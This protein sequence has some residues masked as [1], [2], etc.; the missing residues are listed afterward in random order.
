MGTQSPTCTSAS[1]HAHSLY[2]GWVRCQVKGKKTQ[3]NCSGHLNLIPL[4]LYSK[5]RS[6]TATRRKDASIDQSSVSPRFSLPSF[7]GESPGTRLKLGTVK[8]IIFVNMNQFLP[9][10]FQGNC[11]PNESVSYHIFVL[12]KKRCPRESEVI[13]IKPLRNS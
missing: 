7:K 5:Q 8:V 10:L 4:D 9:H 3:R 2:L 12:F 1:S 6:H 11:L 13:F